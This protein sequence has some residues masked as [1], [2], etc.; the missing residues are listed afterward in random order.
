M[1]QTDAA[2]RS[3][4]GEDVM[5][6]PRTVFDEEHEIF[7]ASVRHF[8]DTE[9]KPHH[10]QWEKD[11]MVSREC[12]LAAGRAGIL[13]T[14]LAEE[15]GGHGGDFL[16]DAVVLEE[17]GRSACTGPGFDLHSYIVA[18]Y[19]EKFG[20]RDQKRQWLPKMASGEAI[21]SIGM[22]EP[23]SGSD[24]RNLRTMA[25][26]KADRYVING[27]KVFI[28]NGIMGD[29]T[30]LATRTGE[31]GSRG[32]TLF[33]IDTAT[34]GYKK[35]RLLDKIGLKAAD[36]AELF[37]DDMEV[38]VECR[39]GEE[40]QGWMMMTS[41]LV[42]ER[43]IVAVRAMAVCEAALDMTVQYTKDRSAFRHQIFDFQNTRF[44]LADLASRI[45]VARVFVDRCIGLHAKRE[46]DM[47]SAAMAKLQITELQDRVLDACLQLHGGYGYMREF[48]IGRLWVDTRIQR[49]YAGS[50]EIM[51][52][53]I[54]RAL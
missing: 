21:G 33:L 39:L 29:V 3:R 48:P 42:Q 49:I 45:Q 11:G 53:I 38:P 25:V 20:S 12:W 18:P 52:E 9:L 41:E 24:L 54:S 44:T 32:I 31:E 10:D 50:N 35:S 5:G 7:R 40:G 15:F 2:R 27:S 6:I 1:S 36:T 4:V 46:L 43:L 30:V 14:S 19:I 17:L 34:K 26:R 8:C 23:H 37:F 47:R 51:K 13:C 22:T 28:T 16:F